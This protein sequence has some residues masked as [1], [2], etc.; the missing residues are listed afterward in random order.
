[1]LVPYFPDESKDD[2]FHYYKNQAGS[3]LGVYQGAPIQRGNGIGSLLKGLVK[4]TLPLLARGGKMLGKRLVSAGANIAK[5]VIDGENF[6][7][8][9]KNRFTEGGKG[10]LNDLLHKVSTNREQPATKRRRKRQNTTNS[11]R[12]ASLF[13][14]VEVKA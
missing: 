1:M 9:A 14:N 11:K 10:L 3:G 2:Y 8:A 12:R 4:S 13:Q 5:D 7:D 6:G